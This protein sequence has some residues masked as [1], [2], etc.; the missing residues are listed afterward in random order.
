MKN[1][2]NNLMPFMAGMMMLGALSSCKKNQTVS[3]EAQQL[4]S[5]PKSTNY[6][7]GSNL[8][9]GLIAYWSC[10][11]NVSD[12]S[13]HG[14]NGTVNGDVT[15]TTDR[16]GYPRGAFYFNGTSSY[17]SVP[18]AA[19]LRLNN[20]DFTLNAWV[21]LDAY[22][23]SYG[24]AIL[25]KRFTGANNGW[26]WTITGNSSSPTGVLSYGP[27]GGSTNAF[28]STVIG[29][30]TWAMVTSI[31]S[32]ANQQ[33]SIYVNGVLD[34]TV[35]GIST[36]NASVTAALYIGRDNPSVASNGYFFQGALDEIR[37]YNRAINGTEL[38]QLYTATSVPTP[39][40]GLVAYWPL[41]NTTGDLSGQGHD[42]TAS[43]ITTT[44][45][46]FNNP[47]GA[48]H[49]NGSSSFISVPGHSDLALSGTDFTINAWVKL[50]SYN[51]SYGSVILGN[52][53]NLGSY[54][55]S[56]SGAASSTSGILSFGINAGPSALSSNTIGLGG[57]H[58]IT[59][60]YI[61]ATSTITLYIDGT[62]NTVSVNPGFAPASVLSAFYIGRDNPGNTGSPGYFLN[63]SLSDIRIYKNALSNTDIQNLYNAL[64]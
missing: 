57:W 8:S 15:V 18:D 10:D 2:K 39:S 33:L 34:H 41:I 40:S 29:T 47:V 48:Y 35:S 53:V 28:G 23:A 9:A 55:V 4:K 3:P 42:G 37:I 20:T 31:Y 5:N 17:M 54:A 14:H 51:S 1:L 46:R 30:G 32:L 6:V 44:S 60:K 45:D 52:R 24:S 12:L 19:E 7:P 27:G 43:N 38:Q 13:G 22:N 63:G 25:T 36:A 58:M 64:N 59:V 50:D 11:N 21:R 62:S 61:L 49:F 26:V 56:I 16:F